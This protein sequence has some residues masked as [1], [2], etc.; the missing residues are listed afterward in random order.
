[1]KS[2]RL[3]HGGG[4]EETWKLVREIFLKYLENPILSSLEDSALLRVSSKLSFT[5]DGFTVKPL[6]FRGGDIGKLAVAGTVNDLAVM[7]AKPLYMSVAFIIEEGFSIEE[8]KRIVESMARTAEEAGV[9]VVAGDTKVVPKGQADG[10]FISCSGIGEVL[11]EGLSCRNIQEGDGILVTGPLGDHG[12]CILA[13]REGFD[14]GEDFES[15]CQPLWDLVEHLLLTGLRVHAMR[16]PTRGGLSAVL[17]EWS[18]SSGL[19][20]LVKEE[21]IPIRTQVQGLCE[22]LGLEPYHLASEGR[23]VLAVH[24][25]DIH[26]A[27]ERLREHPKGKEARHIGYAIRPE[28]H[29]SVILE[30]PYGTKRFLEP[31]VGELLP[32]IC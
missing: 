13:Q 20:F 14:F 28:S 23:L 9:L 32:R 21:A 11:Y 31:P 3:S 24:P 17:H 16:D 29:P 22:F 5:T 18:H 2:I 26:K 15:D 19:S 8:L 12:A 25:E 30:T 1:M 10:L 27:L 6:F 4:G 7:G